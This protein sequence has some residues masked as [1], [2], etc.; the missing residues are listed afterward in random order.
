M[1]PPPAPSF[2]G[3]H[4]QPPLASRA[5]KPP[6]GRDGAVTSTQTPSRGACD[7]GAIRLANGDEPVGGD[8]AQAPDRAVGEAD[9]ELAHV[10]RV[11]E[12]EVRPRVLG[13]EVARAGV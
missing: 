4:R 5:A 13:G 3:R 6:S 7:S 1:V 12:A 10:G 11:A 8:V 9:D 2:S